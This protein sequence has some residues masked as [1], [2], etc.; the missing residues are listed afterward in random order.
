M[1]PTSPCCG[2]RGDEPKFPVGGM[3]TPNGVA[4]ALVTPDPR[5]YGYQLWDYRV[6][7][8]RLRPGHNQALKDL[9]AKITS[10]LRS[11]RFS[12]VN[13]RITV[14]GF[15]S[16]TGSYNHNLSLSYWRMA[17]AARCLECLISQAGLPAGRVVLGDTAGRGYEG[18]VP[19][20]EDPRRRLVQVAVHPP[21]LKPAPVR[22]PSDRFR[23]CVTSLEATSDVSVPF[24]RDV[25]GIGRAKCT[26]RIEDVKTGE[27]QDYRYVGLGVALASPARED[28]SQGNPACPE[29]PG[30]YRRKAAEPN[31]GGRRFTG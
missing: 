12:D 29:R 26:F 25:L 8:Y 21:D 23:L 28:S 30:Q 4:E 7:D 9:V 19:N 24:T 3:A 31:H 6:N 13:W 15:A 11:G 18:A 20:V 1:A 5:V 27:S 14:D 2:L 17:T 22:P 16:R 10:D